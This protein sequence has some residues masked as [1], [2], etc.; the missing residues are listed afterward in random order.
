MREILGK[1]GLAFVAGAVGLA[2]VFWGVERASLL[3]AAA[4]RARVDAVIPGSVYLT[5]VAGV[6]VLSIAVF[7]ALTVVS[8][9]MRA[10]PGARQAPVWVLV[11]VIVAAGGM[12]LVSYADHTNHI[13]S[14]DV[15]PLD[16]AP[17]FIAGQVLAAS[18]VV[19]ALVLLGVRWTPRHRP[20]RAQR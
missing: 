12:G 16:V 13:R 18:I 19:S 4:E 2:L 14:L 15:V 5:L 1:I 9:F 7:S 3:E 17:G 8:N 6:S 20:I 10:H 11:T